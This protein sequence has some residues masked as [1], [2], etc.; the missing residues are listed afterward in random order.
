MDIRPFLGYYLSRRNSREGMS[1]RYDDFDR[2]VQRHSGYIRKKCWWYAGGDGA[3]C[4]ELVQEVLE[5][6]WHYRGKLREGASEL[7]ERTW[8]KYHCRSVFSHRRRAKKVPT[9]DIT[10]VEAAEPVDNMRETLLDMADDLNTREREVLQMLLDGYKVAEIAEHFG[11][12]AHSV[13]QMKLRMIE[14]MRDT[15]NRKHNDK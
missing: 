12:K 7:Q 8:V 2:M 5:Q 13:S 10:G 15:Y 14:K 4:S 1:E 11:L 6:L 9:V 3:L